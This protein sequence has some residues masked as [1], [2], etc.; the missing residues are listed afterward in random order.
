MKSLTSKSIEKLIP[1]P[2]GKPIEE[3]ERE[4]GLTGSIKLASNENPLGPS[5]LAVKAIQREL[6]RLNRYPDGSGYYL[7]TRLAEF[8][9]LPKER[10]IIGNGS[11]ELIELIVRTFVQRED[12]VIQAFPTFLVYEKVVT[13]SGAEL[14]SIPLKNFRLD[15]N[16]IFKA[17][18]HRTKVIF[19]NNPNNPTGSALLK[20]ELKAFLE[21]LPKDTLVIL[22]E[23]YID[24]VCDPEVANGRELL[25][26]FPRIMVLRTFSKLYGLAGLRV[27]YGFADEAI[28]DYMNRVR[29]PFNVNTLAQAGARAA[30]DDV[31]F[32]EQTLD[33]T[34]KGLAYLHRELDKLG[35]EYLPT[36]TNFFLIKVRPGGK[37]VYQQM[38][39]EGVIVR[40]MDSYGLH[41]YIRINIGLPEENERFIRV[42]E[43]VLSGKQETGR[44]RTI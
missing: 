15:L 30:L 19:I 6:T 35:L 21:S 25:D 44:N 31:E 37:Q 38:L 34:R 24:F 41:D 39:K 16:A 1:Y 20:D 26:A 2:P 9:G 13:A 3:L 23:A 33:L 8:L 27:G 42:L 28:I 29:Q 40:S 32:V 4:L 10:I 43:K 7:K 18:N 14:Q 22:D 36:Q 17:V 11:N 5:P 12:K